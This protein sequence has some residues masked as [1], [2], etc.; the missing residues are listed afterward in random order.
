MMHA[1]GVFVSRSVCRGATFERVVHEHVVGDPTSG[2]HD[3]PF[4]GA[5]LHSP[6]A[7]PFRRSIDERFVAARES[8]GA[9]LSLPLQPCAGVLA[10]GMSAGERRIRVGANSIA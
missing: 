5:L 9:G 6:H 2:D 7:A 1:I 8:T 4:Q 3:V 10:T